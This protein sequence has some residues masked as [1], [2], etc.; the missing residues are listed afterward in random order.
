MPLG[1]TWMEKIKLNE[2]WNIAVINRKHASER[3]MFLSRLIV[4]VDLFVLQLPVVVV[5]ADYSR[6]LPRCSTL[7]KNGDAALENFNL[8]HYKL[9]EIYKV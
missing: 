1:F 6:C 9:D 2:P 8:A 7:E 5:L 4:Q 3:C